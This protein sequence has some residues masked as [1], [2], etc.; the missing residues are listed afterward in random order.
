[1]P[2]IVT[3]LL[4]LALGAIAWWSARA[5]ARTLYTGKGS[6]RALPGQHGWHMALWVL[7]P[8]LVGWLIWNAVSPGMIH[9]AILADPAA[10]KLP[11]M[12]MERD[13][14]V[15]EAWI[16]ADRALSG[17]KLRRWL[18]LFL[19]YWR[20]LTG[21]VRRW[22]S[23]LPLLAVPLATPGSRPSSPRALASNAQ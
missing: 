17:P 3:L 8:A 12:E 13:A 6:M 14:I 22:Y 10:A 19:R 11:A 23:F 1:M 18:H 9:A 20:D 21:S 16:A 15:S 5:K 4:L 2:P 7:V